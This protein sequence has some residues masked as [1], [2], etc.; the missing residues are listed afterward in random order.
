V[1][2]SLF[3]GGGSHREVEKTNLKVTFAPGTEQSEFINT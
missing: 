3:V 2:V 1:T